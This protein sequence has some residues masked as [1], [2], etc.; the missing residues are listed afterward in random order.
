MSLVIGFAL[1]LGAS[2][3]VGAPTVHLAGDSTMASYDHSRPYPLYGWGEMLQKFF[4]EPCRVVNHATSGRSSK[5]F[6][7]EGRW[8]KL[9][10]ALQAGDWVIIQFGHNDEKSADPKRYA[11]PWGEYTDNLKRFVADVRAKGAHPIVATS[12][13]RRHW[14]RDGTKMIETHGDYLAAAR[15][16]AETEK[17][18]LLEM[19]GLTTQ[20]AEGHGRE[21]SKR[22]HLWIAPNT[23][24]VKPEGWKDNSHYSAYG[25]ERVA[26]LAVQEI[27]RLQLPLADFLSGD[28]PIADSRPDAAAEK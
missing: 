10:D 27:I 3:A 26:A 11:A 18:P 2:L 7:T 6:I 24:A 13:A 20:L 1:S 22:I 23:Y 16:A 4:Q 9:I 12:V 5:S 17:V 15:K 28:K 25:A 19:H 21:G 8:Q 14:D